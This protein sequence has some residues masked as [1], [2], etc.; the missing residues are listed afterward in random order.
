MTDE[1]KSSCWVGLD[2][3]RAYADST[4]PQIGTE[5]SINKVSPTSG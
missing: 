2:G 5:Q 1:Y 3:Q 4:L